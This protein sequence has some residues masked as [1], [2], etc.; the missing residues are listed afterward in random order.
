AM[1]LNLR[2]QD[3]ILDDSTHTAL[4]EFAVADLLV[5]QGKTDQ[6]IQQL[7]NILVKHDGKSIIDDAHFK[8]GELYYDQK[9]YEKAAEHWKVI[10]KSYAYD[11]LGDAAFYKLGMLY[12]EEFHQPEK[13]MEYYEKI[14]FDYSDSI[15]FVDAR[16]RFRKLRGDFNP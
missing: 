2:I 5:L 8:L 13:A 15:F 4:K 11:L 12:E 3:N 9:N 6:A 1:F 10:T 7:N 16:K 14:I